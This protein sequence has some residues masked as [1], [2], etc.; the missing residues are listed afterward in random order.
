MQVHLDEFKNRPSY[1]TSIECSNFYYIFVFFYGNRYKEPLKRFLDF[2]FKLNFRFYFFFFFKFSVIFLRKNKAKRF[3]HKLFFLI[4]FLFDIFWTFFRFIYYIFLNPF[5]IF[6][7]FIY[8]FFYYSMHYMMT[9][10]FISNIYQGKLFFPL[11]NF[12]DMPYR[13]V[14]KFFK[15][16]FLVIYLFFK[17]FKN[18]IENLRIIYYKSIAFH[19]SEDPE[20]LPFKHSNF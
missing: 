11:F 19:Y 18:S 3:R 9:T 2:Y 14:F 20:H 5:F 7:R 12:Y 16:K 13:Y 15:A 10:Y 17:K 6:F 4:I 8:C 1:K